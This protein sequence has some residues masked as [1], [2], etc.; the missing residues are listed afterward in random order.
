MVIPPIL[1]QTIAE[2]SEPTGRMTSI[3]LET[4][5]GDP[6]AIQ[7]I[8]DPIYHPRWW[9]VGEM[10]KDVTGMHILGI[11]FNRSGPIVGNVSTTTLT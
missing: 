3:P 5:P 6:S 11:G 1:Q 8:T 7:D 9:R 10:N 2:H 4:E